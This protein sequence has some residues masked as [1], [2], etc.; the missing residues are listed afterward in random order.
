MFLT[1]LGGAGTVTGS[2]TLVE[3]GAPGEEQRVLIDCG[4][5]QG[6]REIRERNW[7]TFPIDPATV[8]AVILTHAHLDHCG[9]LP[10]LVREGFAGPVYCSPNTA[11]LVPIILR[12]SAKLQ[13]EDTAWART[14]GFSR[15]ADPRPLYDATDAEHAIALLRPIQFGIDI[16]PIP[17]LTARLAPAGHILGSSTIT[18]VDQLRQRTVV[19]SGDLGRGN[20]PLLE[21]P[22]PP[23][24]ADAVVIESTYGDREHGDVEAEIDEMAAAITRTLHRG[25]TVV[26]PA[27]AVDRTEVLL[28]ALRRLQDQQRIPMA[29]ISVDSPMALAALRVYV[30]A[31]RDHDPEILTA[32][33]A[34][35]PEAIDLPNLDEA[36]TR[37]QSMALDSGGPRIIISASGMAS[38]GRVTHHLKAALPDRRNTILLV[39]YQAVGTPGRLLLD[40]VHELKIHGQYVPVRAEIAEIEAFSVHAGPQELVD[41]IAGTREPPAQVF[42]NHGEP[43]AAEALADRIRD[44]LDVAVV[45][46]QPGDRVRI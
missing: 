38:G 12:D 1:F 37:E 17:S 4:L 34:E 2:K 45:M 30:Q 40:G 7:E 11:D 27:F 24:D 33:D 16:T 43:E 23:E 15:H 20:H 14:K 8:Q 3:A 22:Q 36:T 42:V 44:Q 19:F 26:I 9:Y 25:G 18:L 13:E 28:I 5:F 29:Q 41:W 21:G 10:A 31:I 46:A 32:I 6:P 39:G 35:G